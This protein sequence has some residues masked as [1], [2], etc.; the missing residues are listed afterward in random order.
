[1]AVVLT[2][3]CGTML[4]L[5]GVEDPAEEMRATVIQEI[6]K[7]CAEAFDAAD[8]YKAAKA[9]DRTPDTLKTTVRGLQI[10][11][12]TLQKVVDSK[13]SGMTPGESVPLFE[14]PD[15]V[16]FENRGV[17]TSVPQAY[18]EAFQSESKILAM[19]LDVCMMRQ[20]VID[21]KGVGGVWESLRYSA[22]SWSGGACA[23]QTDSWGISSELP[24]EMVRRVKADCPDSAINVPNFSLEEI[25][26]NVVKRSTSFRCQQKKTRKTGVASQGEA[27]VGNC[28]VCEGWLSKK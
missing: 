27:Q 18:R 15:S 24:G 8:A 20:G 23:E 16:T 26:F 14:E 12:E 1:M 22:T 6:Q 21:Q 10:C 13:V 28:K 4:K 25:S 17:G 3:G 11:R 5:M 2:S 7:S 19:P 9:E